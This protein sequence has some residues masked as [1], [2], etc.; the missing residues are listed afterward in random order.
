LPRARAARRLEILF[1]FLVFA[2]QPLPL[3]L[4]PAEILAQLLVFST[5][6]LQFARRG[7][8]QVWLTARHTMLMPD[9]PQQYK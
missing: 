3:G 7:R 5:K 4:R 9:S 2:T 1:Q 8:R 6:A